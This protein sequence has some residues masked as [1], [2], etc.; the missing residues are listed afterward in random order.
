MS[1]KSLLHPRFPQRLTKRARR[2]GHSFLEHTY[3]YHLSRKDYRHNFSP[4]FYPIYL[5]WDKPAFK[6]SVTSNPFM[7]FLPQMGLCLV[8]GI[9]FS[10]HRSDLPFAWLIQT[11]CFVTFNKVCTS[12]VRINFLD[13]WINRAHGLI[14]YFL[15]YM[16]FLPLIIPK[17]QMSLRAG[18]LCLAAWFGGQAVWLS[19]AYRLEFLGENR[20][21]EVWCASIAFFVINCCII[22][23]MIGA[24]RS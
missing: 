22:A 7:S 11:A 2:W 5:G 14:Q 4:Y 13:H 17:L 12:Q 1:C 10:K 16:W 23:V 3:F 6:W 20:F 21:F 24:Y 9:K 18:I 15:W 19:L 8:T